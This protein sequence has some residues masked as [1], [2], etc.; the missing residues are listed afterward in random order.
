MGPN[1]GEGG[2]GNPEGSAAGRRTSLKT[3]KVLIEKPDIR[4]STVVRLRGSRTGAPKDEVDIQ[5]LEALNIRKI[6][7]VQRIIEDTLLSGCSTCKASQEL[8]ERH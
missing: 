6:S 7:I 2:A 5:L 1:D 3:V 8:D 4:P